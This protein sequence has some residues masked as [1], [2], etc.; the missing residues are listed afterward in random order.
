MQQPA[1]GTLFFCYRGGHG[2]LL[3]ETGATLNLASWLDPLRASGQ[4]LAAAAGLP[5]IVA[6]FQN[7]P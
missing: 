1:S 6:D 7:Q 2:T 5:S 4:R 3:D